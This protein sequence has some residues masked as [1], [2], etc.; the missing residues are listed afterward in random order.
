V[1][2]RDEALVQDGQTTHAR[3]EDTDGAGIHER[4]V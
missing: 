1:R 3:I 4:G 2:E